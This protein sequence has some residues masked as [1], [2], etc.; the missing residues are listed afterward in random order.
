MRAVHSWSSTLNFNFLSLNFLQQGNISTE[1][2]TVNKVGSSVST[3]QGPNI[4]V[5]S[6]TEN[7]S[8][9]LHHSSI[10]KEVKC[11]KS[12]NPARNYAHPR[13]F[14]CNRRELE[15]LHLTPQPMHHGWWTWLVTAER[16]K[17]GW[18]LRHPEMHVNDCCHHTE[19]I[20]KMK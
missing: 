14:I 6:G 20:S 15:L 8:Q 3:K 7:I 1:N 19:L 4:S 9:L 12:T 11:A 5:R 17:H 13:R 16:N 10:N 18:W 2:N